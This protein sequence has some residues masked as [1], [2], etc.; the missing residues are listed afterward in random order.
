LR[1][2]DEGRS[3]RIVVGSTGSPLIDAFGA[4]AE[5]ALAMQVQRCGERRM[6]PIKVLRSSE[7]HVAAIPTGSLGWGDCCGNS[8]PAANLAVCATF[9]NEA[10][11]IEG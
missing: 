7:R 4:A 5:A 9:L 11:R 8:G 3:A 2:T 6:W 10:L 1:E